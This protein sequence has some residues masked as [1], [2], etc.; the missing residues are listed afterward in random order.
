MLRYL[1]FTYDVQNE[2]AATAAAHMNV[3]LGRTLSD[4]WIC[5]LTAPGLIVHVLEDAP[6]RIKVYHLP[7]DR[8]VV[9]GRLFTKSGLTDPAALTSECPIMDNTAQAIVESGGRHL[10]ES[11]WGAYVAF[12]RNPVTHATYVLRDTSGKFLCYRTSH[13]GV[14]I[15]FSDIM[16]L[17]DL[18]LPP[19]TIDWK[20][21]AAFIFSSQ[22]QIRN[23][24][25]N[26]VSEVLAGECFCSRGADNKQICLW[27][28]SDICQ[29]GYLE[30][31]AEAE[32]CLLKTTQSCVL[33]WAA[34]YGNVLLY[35]SG[36]FDS[37]VVLGCLVS[38]SP[39]TIVNC[40]N[41]FS[42]AA[43]E[44]ERAF[45][46]IAARQA[47]IQL[48]EVPWTEVAD[49]FDVRLFAGPR[50]AKP[51]TASLIN[52]PDLE[53]RRVIAKRVSANSVWTGQ[54]GDHL[55]FQMP[56]GLAAADYVRNRGIDRH[57][58]RLLDE[59]AR[60]AG[61]SYWAVL[62]DMRR[63]P[64]VGNPWKP[65]YVLDRRA[66]F[67]RSSALPDDLLEY[68]EHPWT[69]Q[70]AHLPL[71]QQCKIQHY[72]EVLNR[73]RPL[74]R[75][76]EVP[77]HHPL[78]SQPLIELC[79]RIPLYHLVRGGRARS[80]ARDAFRD[81]VPNEIL[82]RESKG[83][84]T[85]TSLKALRNNLGFIRS[86]LMDGSLRKE[87]LLDTEAIRP[88]LELTQPLRTEEFFPLFACL[89]A[90]VFIT[91]WSNKKQYTARFSQAS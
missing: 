45:A 36:G 52:F 22:L 14:S 31:C 47:G 32:S 51:S 72:G 78:L 38:A 17:E 19:P 75:S 59:S 29:T 55:F 35:L 1:A 61:D 77:E 88:Y 33:A 42:P 53:Q 8:G 24:A 30:D 87:G 15:F 25:L 49:S 18:P 4:K 50:G 62:R 86:I 3:A 54:G 74:P 13:E 83:N 6:S 65:R 43:G 85:S 80:L 23:C 69:R 7:G 21:I 56:T 20:Y 90:E 26:E 82:S 34:V 11:F 10:V 5:A 67:V 60:F 89:A 58:F 40:V 28:P 66:T 91:Q 57:F 37:A 71:G 46:E 73:H 9:I 84:S 16:D 12:L 2:R 41:R 27:N 76:E 79:L 44:D 63:S 70:S 39:K 81:R 48:L 64:T 68:L